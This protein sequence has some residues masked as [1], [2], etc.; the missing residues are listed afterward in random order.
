MKNLKCLFAIVITLFSFVNLSAQ[1]LSDAP[2]QNCI[3]GIPVCKPVYHQANSYLGV[4]TDSELTTG[5]YDC[6]PTADA[7]LGGERNSVWYI[8]HVIT[9]GKIVFTITPNDSV[10]D[11]DWSMWDITDSG[12]SA[13]YNYTTNTPLNYPSVRCNSSGEV[14]VTGLSFFAASPKEGPGS[15]PPMS[16]ALPVIAGQTFALCVINWTESK[17][18][19]TLDFS[20][21]TA[22]IYDTVRPTF[23]SIS[24]GACNYPNDTLYVTMSVPVLCSTLDPDGSDFHLSPS[25]P[26]VT[27]N[28]AF[29]SVCQAGATITTNYQLVLSEALPPGTYSLHSQVGHDTNT[30]IDNCVNEQS[31]HDSIVFTIRPPSGASSDTTICNGDTVKL[32]ISLNVDT[33]VKIR[34]APNSFISNDTIP[35]PKAT[36]KNSTDYVATLTYNVASNSCI[37]TDTEHVKVLEWYQFN[38]PDTSIC[39]NTAVQMRVSGDAHFQYK[40]TPVAGLS[41]PNIINPI[42]RPDSNITYTMTASYPGCKDSSS[43]VSIAII[44]DPVPFK[45]VGDTLICIGVPEQLGVPTDSV[46]FLWNTGDTSCCIEVSQ[47]GKYI[48]HQ[49]NRCIISV[50]DSINIYAY[51]C[52]SCIWVPSAFTPNGDG[53]NDKFDVV[54]R[55]PLKSYQLEIVN[56]FGQVVFLSYNLNNKWDGTQGG[57]PVEIGTYYYFIKYTRNITGSPEESV[58]GDVTVI[59]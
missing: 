18:G 30:L 16:S 59:R 24:A 2:E 51:P 40:W 34:W 56:R 25:V 19:Y 41:N 43:S 13:I 11:Y 48:L 14:P 57:V 4:G 1:T 42:A 8:I 36:P 47:T 22:S 54:N 32:H 21:S 49:F 53:K 15:T 20:N 3:G 33:S 28:Q 23:K 17:F 45:L 46:T 37:A 9:P 6:I 55:C 12:C 35:N 27:I 26:G 52:D 39:P 38:N 29:S 10:D 44:P 5:N 31:T 7:G 58:K 50:A